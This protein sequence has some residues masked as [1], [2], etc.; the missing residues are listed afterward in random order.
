MRIFVPEGIL[1]IGLLKLSFVSFSYCEQLAH[2]HFIT[3]AD[4]RVDLLFG[5]NYQ[6]QIET[7]RMIFAVNYREST[8]LTLNLP[9]PSEAP[10]R[11]SERVEAPIVRVLVNENLNW[12]ADGGGGGGAV[13]QQQVQQQVQQL[14]Q[15]QQQHQQLQQILQQQPQQQQQDDD[16]D[17][18]SENEDGEVRERVRR[19]PT[20]LHPIGEDEIRIRFGFDPLQPAMRMDELSKAANLSDFDTTDLRLREIVTNLSAFITFW[21]TSLGIYGAIGSLGFPYMRAVPMS[22]AEKKQMI[23]LMQLPPNVQKP[24]LNNYCYIELGLPPGFG[25]GLPSSGCWRM[26]GFHTDKFQRFSQ[27]TDGSRKWLVGNAIA[28]TKYIAGESNVTGLGSIVRSSVP[29]EMTETGENLMRSWQKKQGK[30]HATGLSVDA[31]LALRFEP[32]LVIDPPD[33]LYAVN[34]K[35][36][37]FPPTK[38]ETLAMLNALVD[39]TMAKAK[40]AFGCKNG[41]RVER[42]LEIV[43]GVKRVMVAADFDSINNGAC[44]FVRYDFGSHVLARK[45][46]ITTT[47]V[48]IDFRQFRGRQEFRNRGALPVHLITEKVIETAD[49]DTWLTKPEIDALHLQMRNI[50]KRS[51]APALKD[52]A[53]LARETAAYQKWAD[54]NPEQ[55]Q[56]QQQE[57]AEE[58]GGEAAGGVNDPPADQE[59]EAA[60]GGGGG[61][62][63]GD[64]QPVGDDGGGGGAN[65][66]AADDGGGGQDDD[67]QPAADDDDQP[68]ADGGGGGGGNNDDPPLPPIRVHIPNP[69]PRPRE[70]YVPLGNV[71]TGACAGEPNRNVPAN[72]PNAFLVISENGE[73]RDFFQE[74]GHVCL[75]GRF[76]NNGIEL[77]K[78]KSFVINNGST[79]SHYL[80]FFVYNAK[81][82]QLY[83]NRSPNVGLARCMLT[84]NY[85]KH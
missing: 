67:D 18:V 42:K 10:R 62:N 43:N 45:F 29:L 13:P 70:S 41:F 83:E 75:A 9:P 74:L 17:Y 76:S 11:Q 26:L 52:S 51:V 79:G 12:R 32:R 27:V 63:V 71:T 39:V 73:R 81:T 47:D 5:R 48:S 69:L 3:P 54:E 14:Q 7:N 44:F 66:P 40:E 59:E 84:L 20:T 50:V 30:E 85:E 56:Q 61:G 38:E 60:G 15:M 58:G 53:F 77:D 78:S 55:P 46:G 65:Q 37:T 1:P 34:L 21:G 16:D 24:N 22:E 31:M 2:N 57:Q 28:G 19:A 36:Y 4:G 82:M 64:D 80:D 6:P 25:L 68:A 23:E 49:N 72:F 33:Y 35:R 8:R